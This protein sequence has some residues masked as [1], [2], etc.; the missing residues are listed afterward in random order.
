M[1]SYMARGMRRVPT[2]Y[3]DLVD[4]IGKNPG[5]VIGSTA[6]L[7]GA[8]PTQLL[9]FR[10]TQNKSILDAIENWIR[11]MDDLFGHGN[12]YLELQP[13]ANDD[14][15]Y[16]NLA[17]LRLSELLEIPYIITTDSHYLK[18][19]DA[20]IHKAFLNS[21]D[22]DR[23]VD[24]FY[25]TTYLMGTEELESFLDYMN[26]EQLEQAYK[27]I[28]HIANMCENYSLKKPLRI[29]DLPWKNYEGIE[30]TADWIE[31]MPMLETFIKSDYKGDNVLAK[32]VVKKLVETETLRNK[33]TYDEINMNLDSIWTSSNVNKAHWSA[34]LLN[35]QK[36][37]DVC[38]DAGSIVG[39]GRGSGV[40][41]LLLYILDI[42]QINPLWE[43]TQCFAWRFLNPE[44]V[45]VL[46]V[47][48]DIEGGRRDEVLKAF[49]TQY[50]EDRVANV[51]TFRTE[52]SKSAVL[53]A[54]RGLGIDVDIA[55]YLSSL[56]PADRGQL[57]SLKQCYYGDKDKDFEP[58][59]QF[60]IEMDE[61][62]PE[63]WEVAQKIEGL[64]C[65][66][67]VHAGG[68]IFVDEPFT[69]STALMRAPD[70]TICTQFELHDA[71]KAS[72]IK[73]DAL[74]VEGMDKIHTCID[75]LCEY[76]YAERKPTLKETY[77]DIIGI[78]KIEREDEKMWQM[79]WDHKIASLF[80]MEKQSGVQG[81]SLVKPKNVND[82][83]VLNSVIRLMASE[84]GGEIP[85]NMWARYRKNI[86]L[87]IREMRAY[88]LT[89]DEINWLKGHSAIT[90]GI[91]ES[92]EGL[93]S[94]VQEE[95][96]GG[97][98]LGY[99]DKCRKGLA[100]KIGA[101]F[102]ECEKEFFET[103]EEKGLS[104]R[105]AHYV[106]DVLLKVQ[107]GY[108]FNRSHCLA[109]SLVAL[110]EMNLAYKYPILFWNC[111]CLITD[112]GGAELIEESEN[113][114]DELYRGR[115]EYYYEEMEE[116][117]EDD[118]E[119]DIVSSYPED[120]NEILVMKSGRK[121]KKVKTTN[122]GKIASAIGKM[123]SAGVKVMPPDINQSNYTFSPD[124]E[125][126]MIRYGLSGITR[127]N[128]D[129]IR[130]IMANR[131]YESFED[132]CIKVPL[133]KPVMINLIKAG[134]FDGFEDREIVM[135]SYIEMIAD[136]KGRITMQNLGML[137]EKD[138][139]PKKFSFEKKVFNYN[140]YVKKLKKGDYIYLD[141]IAM[142]FYEENFDIDKLEFDDDVPKIKATTW[143]S[144][145]DEN[146]AKVKPYIQKNSQ[147]LL[148]KLNEKILKET[149]EK[150]CEGTLSSWEMDS[151]SFYSH[152]HELERINHA[153][154]GWSN[155]F[156]LPDEPPI[157]KSFE[158]RDGKVIPIYDIHR[159]AGTVLD[160]DKNKKTITL[161]T[162]YGVVVVKMF[163]PMFANYDKQISEK[164][165]DGKKEVKEKSWFARGNKIIICGIKRDDS[166]VAK[167]YRNTEHHLVELITKIND[168]GTYE[169]VGKRYGDEED[170]E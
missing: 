59:R 10:D 170:E 2:Y 17:L 106:W 135:A 60:I 30:V 108:S 89:E 88:G 87:W 67:G 29:P 79:V 54:C 46:D 156:K 121:K 95:R 6:C 96:L 132:F 129:N 7:G 151:V 139:L 117:G 126:N 114:D 159:I 64:I 18:K 43:T 61:N 5:H 70:G 26:E 4:I 137:I 56:I 102:D 164:G 141:E 15:V 162:V 115:L 86:N 28:E 153:R 37:I 144:I 146:M 63:V 128:D 168:D 72:L 32:A 42:T 36:I 155:Y 131:P 163:G 105:L 20:M 47:D 74:S 40:G 166:F 51:A 140:K 124:V 11:S 14:Q 110:Q 3:Q 143:K 122:Y 38:W 103:V 91:C 99:A 94:L 34:Y 107:R 82:L 84:K 90:D 8:I 109:Y 24:D 120:N 25:A 52:K 154:N 85:L 66:S 69:D 71:E 27:N 23:E 123:K 161:L 22:G 93:M 167:K 57:R 127:L 77:E 12:F 97:H 130:T 16:V 125:N 35:L 49:R 92:Q 116:F 98:S 157:T 76:G 101:I 55:Q 13:S 138:L 21:Q 65:G 44:R 134:A 145:Y 147:E 45:S 142:A 133:T 165:P 58:I 9:K 150:Y 62:Y 113:E 78:Y 75:L 112:S 160:R 41:F 31:K 33:E 48:F 68:V 169:S 81:I 53:T 152:E 118:N 80:Q 104:D 111:A 50:G 119:D 149:W 19:E 100:K 158:T 39:P 1:R 148:E 136:T 83:A 73:Y